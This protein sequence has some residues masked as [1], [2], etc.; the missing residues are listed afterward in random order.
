M[1]QFNKRKGLLLII[2]A[3]G[4]FKGEIRGV[5]GVRLLGAFKRSVT[6]KSK[7]Y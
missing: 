6:L 1:R 7:D 3:R 4:R 5:K 2:V